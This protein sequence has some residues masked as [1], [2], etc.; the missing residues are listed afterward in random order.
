MQKQTQSRTLG[1][2]LALI[3]L[4][5][6]NT[7]FSAGLR[8]YGP[9]LAWTVYFIAAVLVFVALRYQQ[10]LTTAMMAA[11]LALPFAVAALFALISPL[12]GMQPGS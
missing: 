5:L 3:G 1:V 6:V 7:L 4:A 11:L 8:L 12:L 9:W 10:R 2:L